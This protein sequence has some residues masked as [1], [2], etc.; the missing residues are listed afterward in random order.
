MLSKEHTTR[1]TSTHSSLA[2]VRATINRFFLDFFSISLYCSS[3]SFTIRFSASRTVLDTLSTINFTYDKFITANFTML[4]ITAA[5]SS[6]P[7]LLLLATKSASTCR[8]SAVTK[9]IATEIVVTI[10]NH[11]IPRV[12]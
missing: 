9:T 5:G 12:W 11:A 3:S 8:T 2:T 1:K 4:I 6:A 10:L 7:S